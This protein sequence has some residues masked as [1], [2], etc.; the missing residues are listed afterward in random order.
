MFMDLNI[1]SVWVLQEFLLRGVSEALRRVVC[2]T[3]LIGKFVVEIVLEP[4]E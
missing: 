4:R 1:D 3:F 2:T